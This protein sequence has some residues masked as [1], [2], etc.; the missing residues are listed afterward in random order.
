MIN[1]AMLL[2]GLIF[3][4]G[5]ARVEV[6]A[7]KEP[8]K[9]DISMRLDIYQH[10][11]KDIDA[12]ES[13]VSGGK[14]KQSFLDYFISNAYAEEGLSSEVEQAALRRR[15]RLSEL[16]A[17]QSKGVIGEN[18]RGFVEIVKQ[19][20]ADPSLG[21]LVNQENSDRRI[22]YES[23]AKKNNTTVGEIEKLYAQR[24]QS[25]APAGCPIETLDQA[26]G[27]YQWKTK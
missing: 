23:L 4:L 11:E 9:V 22:I 1:V 25:S 16:S 20:S 3:S 10:V 21:Q 13:I 12:I 2:L 14:E 19:S 6:Q 17:W 18:K 8:I 15:D 24:L 26:T 5:C 27:S 7:P